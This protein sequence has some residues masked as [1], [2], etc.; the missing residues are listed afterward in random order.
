MLSNILD[1][2][3]FWSLFAVITLLPIFFLP[4]TRIPIDTSKGFILVVGLSI[5]IIFWAMARFFDGKIVLPK[6]WVL[7][8]GLGVVLVSLI[9]TIFSKTAGFSFFGTMLDTGSFYFILAMFLL[10]FLSSVILRDSKKS[11]IVFLGVIFSS[12]LALVFQ[13]FFILFPKVLNLGILTKTTDSLV[14]SFNSLGIFAG[15]VIIISLFIFSFFSFSKNMKYFL[16]F[17]ILLSIFLMIL[18]NFSFA[19]LL[20]GIFAL[21]LFVYKISF[22]SVASPED[23]KRSV[24]A[25]VS[26]LIVVVSLF[27]YIGGSSVGGFLSNRLGVSNLEVR[28]SFSSTMIVAKSSLAKDPILGSGPNKFSQVWDLYKPA[29]INSTI[30]WDTSF[31]NG[32]G[33]LPTFMINT[34]ILGI[35][36]WIFFI[37]LMVFLG[38]RELFSFHRKGSS[39]VEAVLFFFMSLYLFISS[40][41]YSASPVIFLLAFAFFGMFMGLSSIK[42]ENKEMNIEFLTD[43]RKS[44]FVIILLIVVI[45]ASITACFKYVERFVSIPYFQKTLASNS[46]ELAEKNVNKAL[47]LYTNDLYLRTYTQVYLLKFGALASK[48]DSIT[49]TEK[50]NLK[51]SFDQ[52]V[53]SAQL[54]ITYNDSNYLNYKS[55]GFAYESIAPFGV[56]NAYDSAIDAYKKASELN[57]LNPSL[58]LSIARVYFAD[59]NITEAKK[60]ANKALELKNDYVDALIVLSQIFKSQGNIKEATKYA[61]MALSF[62]PND[63]QLSKYVDSLSISQPV[64]NNDTTEDQITD[65]TI[66]E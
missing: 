41:F 58:N 55:L 26:F 20:L 21:I 28:P 32:S 10:M 48:G 54:A 47:S 11:K 57:P 53:T 39:N 9:S 44:F 37:F 65:Q 52:L 61:Q 16:G 36:S 17:V 51:I 63:E 18:V 7:L 43:P 33:L 27:F 22:S 24:F 23:K 38:I 4:F 2:I 64:A 31:E 6:S 49:E 30:F 59:K 19:W 25:I 62:V 29:V 15:L 14:G 1:R 13:V 8:S 50:T 34:G 5:S 45:L 42:K 46:I 35:L 40:F 56:E 3:S 66:L 12:V 60:Y